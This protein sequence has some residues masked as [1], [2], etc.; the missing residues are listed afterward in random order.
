VRKS[1][2]KAVDETA[3]LHPNAWSSVEVRLIDCSA[4]GFRAQ[5]EARVNNCDEVMLEV[6]GIGPAKAYVRWVR[7]EEFGAHF[8][9]PIAIERAQ[10]VPAAAAKLLARLLVQR[11]SARKANLREHEERLRG[12]IARTLPLHGDG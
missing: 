2:R 3:R 1:D 12:E 9:E 4:T 8:V 10:L 11:A 5:S 6:P 7:G